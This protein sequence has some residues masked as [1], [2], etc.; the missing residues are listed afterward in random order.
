MSMIQLL[1]LLYALT[2]GDYFA[3]WF[4]G[5]SMHLTVPVA[6]LLSLPKFGRKQH[7][8]FSSI[9]GSESSNEVIGLRSLLAVISRD[10]FL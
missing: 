6:L 2:D 4:H 7:L 1:K 10:S 8:S 5:S 3:K 9:L